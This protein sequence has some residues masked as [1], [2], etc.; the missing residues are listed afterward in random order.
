[1]EIPLGLPIGDEQAKRHLKLVCDGESVI[2]NNLTELR[3]GVDGGED[4]F[5][6]VFGVI[7]KGGC[8]FEQEDFLL[9][10]CIRYLGPHTTLVIDLQ[11]FFLA[12][13]S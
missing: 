10:V 4:S 9:V 8:F 5:K 3:S 6:A 7:K 13:L 12:K 2:F 11:Q 1:M